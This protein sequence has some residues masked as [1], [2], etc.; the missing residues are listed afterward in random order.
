MEPKSIQEAKN[1]SKRVLRRHLEQ[2][3]KKHATSNDFQTPWNTKNEASLGRALKFHLGK[4]T[5]KI[6]QTKIKMSSKSRQHWVKFAQRRSHG[7]TGSILE[8]DVKIDAKSGAKREP[9]WS[10]KGVKYVKMHPECHGK[11]DSRRWPAPGGLVLFGV[12]AFWSLFGRK[13]RPRGRF[14][15]HFGTFFHQTCDKKSIP[16]SSL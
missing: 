6:I 12:V 4:T 1:C 14:E 2:M 9:T 15:F 16:K 7:G 8:N 11:L 3:L 10:P 5:Q 13:G